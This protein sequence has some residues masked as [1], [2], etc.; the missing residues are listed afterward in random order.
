[1]TDNE[2]WLRGEMQCELQTAIEAWVEKWAYGRMWNKLTDG[3]TPCNLS[4]DMAKA[5]WNEFSLS[6]SWK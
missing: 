2:E 1:M 4:E 5:A 3:Y 6:D